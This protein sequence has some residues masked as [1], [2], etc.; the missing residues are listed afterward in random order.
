M[1]TNK[2]LLLLIMFVGITSNFAC[3]KKTETTLCDKFQVTI[4]NQT[5]K[6][7]IY[8]QINGG[9]SQYVTNSLVITVD[10]SELGYVIVDAN[11]QNQEFGWKD[12]EITSSDCSPQTCIWKDSDF[13][14]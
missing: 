11:L 5:S 12:K 10:A 14:K 7:G 3:K 13:S 6:E 2:Y 8:I 1:K 9:S 4:I